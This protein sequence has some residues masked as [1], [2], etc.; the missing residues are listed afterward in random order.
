MLV[1]LGEVVGD[2]GE[3]RVDVGAAKLL[4]RDLFARGRLHER[5]AAEEDRARAL[6]DDGLV[7]HRGH[8]GAARRAGAHHHRD[9][10]DP[11]GRHPRLVEEDAP[12]VVAIGEDLGLQRQERAAR[13]HEVDAGQ[14]VLEAISWARRCFL[15]V[16]GK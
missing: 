7:G 15:T 1:V 16:S 5:R 3:P 9:L 13:V 4:G 10:R 8:V 12:E 2:A 11:L 14:A 6:D